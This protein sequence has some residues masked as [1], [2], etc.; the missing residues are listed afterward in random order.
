M[1][2]AQIRKRHW[3]LII[4]VALFVPAFMLIVRFKLYVPD[5]LYVAQLLRESGGGAR[6]RYDGPAWLEGI[7]R[8]YDIGF[9]DKLIEVD[10]VFVEHWVPPAQFG[11]ADLQRLFAI[12]SLE[13]IALDDV[14]VADH[15]LAALE[16]NPNLTSLFLAAPQITSVGW[17]HI[18]QVAGLRNL[19]LGWVSIDAAGA[20]ALSDM[21]DLEGLRLDSCTFEAEAFPDFAR[22]GSLKM[23]QIYD[24]AITP[25]QVDSIAKLPVLEEIRF[26]ASPLDDAMLGRLT[27]IRSLKRIDCNHSNVTAEGV[28]RFQAARPDCEIYAH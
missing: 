25:A 9:F 18:S 5:S 3:L 14:G 23:L 8:K 2:R 26:F 6:M 27:S 16:N 7:C 11:D 17:K 21:S 28:S 20:A 12:Q 10:R 19:G 13:R 1:R 22:L 4:A 24:I 15:H